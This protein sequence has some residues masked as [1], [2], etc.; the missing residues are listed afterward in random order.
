MDDLIYEITGEGTDKI[1]ILK[2]E[3]QMIYKGYAYS[4]VTSVDGVLQ[5]KL[6]FGLSGIEY[7]YCI[8]NLEDYLLLLPVNEQYRDAKQIIFSKSSLM[9]L[10]NEFDYDFEDDK[11]YITNVNHS[12]IALH[13]FLSSG[14]YFEELD[15]ESMRKKIQ[16]ITV[17]CS[18]ENYH[19]LFENLISKWDDIHLNNLTK[20][21]SSCVEISIYLDQKENYD[22]KAFFLDEQGA[23]YIKISPDL[24]L[25][26]NVFI[27]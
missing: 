25:K 8:K 10:W 12:D 3:S 18:E 7:L 11:E 2:V 19:Y 9:K 21:R 15:L 16:K 22:W 23:V 24:G 26:S 14:I 5:F 6:N 4:L 1:V 17:G 13:W 20:I 27:S